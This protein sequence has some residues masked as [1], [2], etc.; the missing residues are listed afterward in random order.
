MTTDVHTATETILALERAALDRWNS[1]DVEGQLEHYSE[2]VT[3]FDPLVE[4]LRRPGEGGR[5]LP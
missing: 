3:Y 4:M 2:D 1:G 5:V